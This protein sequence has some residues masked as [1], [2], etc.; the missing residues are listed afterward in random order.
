M[1]IAWSPSHRYLA[2]QPN[3]QQDYC[4]KIF[5]T[6]TGDVLATK[7]GCFSGDPSQS[8]DLRTFVGWLDDD[9]F[10]G[11]VDIDSATVSDPVRIVRVNIHTQ[12]ETPVKSYAW[13]SDPKLRGSYLFFGGR[14]NPNDT[15]A[16]L[17]RLSLAD[18]SETRLVSL[19]LSGYGGCQVGIGPCSWTAPWDVSPDGTRVLYH[20]PGAD[21]LP[22]DTQGP[23]DTPIYYASVDGS[24]AVRVLTGLGAQGLLG[25][26]FDLTGTY[27][28]AFA[29]NS[30]PAANP[31][32]VYQA[33]PR[34]AIARVV[35]MYYAYW[36]SDGQ[37]V[38]DVKISYSGN[39]PLATATLHLLA[40]RTDVPLAANT[41]FYLW[42]N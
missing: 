25:P 20:N 29:S 22:S 37:A 13:M 15:T 38:V 7:Y 32:F 41:Y 23:H 27:A 5:D 6:N 30:N 1:P 11:R 28:T 8:G 17:Y 4:L 26:A 36:R 34:G 24:G 18:G 40:G 19:G 33:L 21:I 31:D 39:T 16:Y 14:I 35:N 42:A 10:L 3:L 12:A 9:T 2:V